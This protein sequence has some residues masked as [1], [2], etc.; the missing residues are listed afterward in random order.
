[1]DRYHLSG[2]SPPDGSYPSTYA[3]SIKSGEPVIKSYVGL[4]PTVW[5]VT[6][7]LPTI[8]L[9]CTSRMNDEL[10]SSL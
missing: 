1:M 10:S 3:T 7:S 4:S 5:K 2:L 6:T 8:Q 9:P